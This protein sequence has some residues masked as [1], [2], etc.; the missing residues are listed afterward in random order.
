MDGRFYSSMGLKIHLF[1][2]DGNRAESSSTLPKRVRVNIV[3]NNGRGLSIDVI[4]ID[5]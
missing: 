5:L 3:Y 4:T 1:S 2:I